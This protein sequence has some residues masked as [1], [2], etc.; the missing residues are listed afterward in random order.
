MPTTFSATSLFTLDHL[1]DLL[2]QCGHTPG[3]G[4]VVAKSTTIQDESLPALFDFS[5]SVDL[6]RDVGF[7]GR[8]NP[9]SLLGQVWVAVD[10]PAMSLRFARPLGTTRVLTPK[11][12]GLK[13][14]ST[15]WICRALLREPARRPPEPFPPPSFPSTRNKLSDADL[16]ASTGRTSV[17][18]PARPKDTGR[19]SVDRLCV[20]AIHFILLNLLIARN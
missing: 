19:L 9:A 18:S 2:S 6:A 11:V 8:A 13:P 10:Q 14:A 12:R 17:W 15:S 7:C 5:I 1:A 3:N 16:L 4:F 20:Q